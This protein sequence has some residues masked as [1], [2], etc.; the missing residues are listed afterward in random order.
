LKTGRRT[1]QAAEIW[2]AR[3]RQDYGLTA[4][5]LRADDFTFN[6]RAIRH[7][8]IDRRPPTSGGQA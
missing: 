4:I 1:E 5:T 6:K 7:L 8:V 3:H 2:H